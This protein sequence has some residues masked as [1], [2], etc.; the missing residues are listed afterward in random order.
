MAY[1]NVDQVNT[2]GTG[3][4]PWIP[5]NRWSNA[6]NYSIVTTVNGTATYTVELT[7]VQLNRKTAAEIA[8]AKVCAVL[9][10]TALEMSS[11]LSVLGTPA[12]FFRINQT[13]G[14]GSVD[15][16]IMQSGEH[17]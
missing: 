1:I 12:E 4:K 16:Q 15:M 17:V 13:A 10:A 11:C 6:G 7:L 3:E 14:T 5:V 9:N 2:T 8:A